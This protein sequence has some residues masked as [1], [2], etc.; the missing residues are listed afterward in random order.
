M[1]RETMWTCEIG[2]I[3]DFKLPPGSDTPMR[4][5]IAKAFHEVT[6]REPQFCFSG[7]GD[8]LEEHK[9]EVL[10][11]QGPGINGVRIAGSM[12]W[13]DAEEW[14]ENHRS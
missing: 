6:G 7:W 5:A 14:L 11:E 3:G 8:E 9:R 12:P 4:E 10:R 13:N 2:I 1:K